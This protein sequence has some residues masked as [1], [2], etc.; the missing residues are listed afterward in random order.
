MHR[1]ERGQCCPAAKGKTWITIGCSLSGLWPPQIHY[2]VGLV[3]RRVVLPA[4][5][6]DFSVGAVHDVGAVPGALQPSIH[7]LFNT[8]VAG[9]DVFADRGP[10]ITGRRNALAE[11][12]AVQTVMGKI[13]VARHVKRMGGA[14]IEQFAVPGHRR[15][16]GIEGAAATTA[17]G[18]RL[19]DAIEH[20]LLEVG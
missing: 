15:N 1:Y 5:D 17:D 12:A 10:C 19:I 18:A 3:C 9:C 16:R 7:H 11:G 2:P 13:V 20:F 8:G 4:G 6:T 14:G